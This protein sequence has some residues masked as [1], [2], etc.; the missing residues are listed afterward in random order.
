MSENLQGQQNRW[1]DQ[2]NFLAVGRQLFDP[3][4]QELNRERLSRLFA[5]NGAQYFDLCTTTISVL[6]QLY[7]NLQQVWAAN[8]PL[9]RTNV[10]LVNIQRKYR[11]FHEYSVDAIKRL[12]YTDSNGDNPA[13][14][15]RRR[16]SKK[17]FDNL[18]ETLR[19][20]QQR[21]FRFQNLTV[22]LADEITSLESSIRALNEMMET[23][24]P[25]SHY[26]ATLADTKKRRVTIMQ[27]ELGEYDHWLRE[28]NYR[29]YTDEFEERIIRT[30][31][32][33]IAEVAKLSDEN[34]KFK[35]KIQNTMKYVLPHW[36]QL[37]LP[38]Q[39]LSLYTRLYE[40]LVEVTVR[41]KLLNTF[42]GSEV[43]RE[44]D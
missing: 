5:P 42:S 25:L 44:T 41:N 43:P 4:T 10:R 18:A 29:S 20:D 34:V 6:E 38:N 40:S 19:Q 28:K 21:I 30:L 7:R 3:Q 39:M 24:D 36:Q 17:S 23:D 33:S 12:L 26:L 35:E 9:L 37:D 1:L 14:G 27:R 22:R 2:T 11:A 8:H 16:I 32:E 31:D 15:I 13:T